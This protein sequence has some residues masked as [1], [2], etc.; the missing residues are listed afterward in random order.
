M[1]GTGKR[2]GGE[3][4]PAFAAR[5]DNP[6][7]PPLRHKRAAAVATG[8]RSLRRLVLQPRRA[9]VG[10]QILGLMPADLAAEACLVVG[11]NRS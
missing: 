2:I 1:P 5:M 7:P 8:Q 9:A 3:R 6:K 11:A 10:L 4:Q